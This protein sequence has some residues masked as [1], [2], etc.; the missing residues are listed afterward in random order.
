MGCPK[1]KHSRALKC[2][3]THARVASQELPSFRAHQLRIIIAIKRFAAHAKG[4]PEADGPSG[5][6]LAE[7]FSGDKMFSR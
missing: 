7:Q 2:T 6:S 4:F 5:T 3:E 1:T